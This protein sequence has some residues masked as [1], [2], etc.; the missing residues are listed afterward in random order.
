MLEISD[1]K[2]LDNL[3]KSYNLDLIVDFPTRITHSMATLI[4]CIFLDTL[5]FKK[6]ISYLHIHGLSDHE[7]QIVILDSFMI[8]CHK[9]IPKKGF[10]KLINKHYVTFYCYYKKK[11]GIQVTILLILMKCL[12][13]FKIFL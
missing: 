6:V 3:M 13:M 11:S 9:N 7:A 10:I 8:E 12:K 1:K 2:R 5:Q 4:D